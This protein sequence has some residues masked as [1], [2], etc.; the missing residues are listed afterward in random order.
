MEVACSL[1]RLMQ[2]I[3][4]RFTCF[5]TVWESF[6]SKK[7]APIS[8]AVSRH[9]PLMPSNNQP[10]TTSAQLIPSNLVTGLGAGLG[11]SSTSLTT[12]KES[13]SQQ[14]STGAIVGIVLAFVI[15]AV[16]G[17]CLFGRWKKQRRS[18]NSQDEDDEANLESGKDKDKDEVASGSGSSA[19]LGSD[20]VAVEDSIS[21]SGERVR[22]L[23]SNGKVPNIVHSYV[24]LS[25]GARMGSVNGSRRAGRHASYS[26]SLSS[27]A[28]SSGYLVAGGA[29]GQGLY[30]PQQHSPLH[31]SQSYMP[32]QIFS[33]PSSVFG[34]SSD[35]PGMD[36]LKQQ[37]RLSQGFIDA[38][39]QAYFKY[40][41]QGAQ[42]AVQQAYYA[43][44]Q[45]QNP[46]ATLPHPP[47]APVA[48]MGGVAKSAEI[49]ATPVPTKL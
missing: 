8:T 34:G 46:F 47:S 17:M 36:A 15:A 33:P 19:G 5:D 29:G 12:E 37:R 6:V 11:T 40:N 30:Y 45:A 16:L 28:G 23:S 2:S 32:P 1:T 35:A 4:K 42:L 10:T 49:V 14:V 44:H 26:D 18:L 9:P 7:S 43:Q 39:W 41:P 21:V 3:K 13:G 31:Q 48:G 20:S 22:N 25:R 27:D 38:W 24:D